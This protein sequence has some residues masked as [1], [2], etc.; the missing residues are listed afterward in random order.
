MNSYIQILKLKNIIYLFLVQLLI[1]NTEHITINKSTFWLKKI[2]ANIDYSGGIIKIVPSES[3]N[4]LS[5]FIEYNPELFQPNLEFTSLSRIGILDLSTNFNFGLNLNSDK[6]NYGNT[7]EIFLPTATPIKFNLNYSLATVEMDLN[8]VE[9][10]T[11]NFDLGLGSAITNFGNEYQSDCGFFNVDIG[12]GSAEFKNIGNLNCEEYEIA[13]GMGSII[14][15]FS[16]ENN[17]DIEYEISLGMGYIEIYVPVNKNVIFKTNQSIL[18]NLDLKE[19]N[20]IKTNIYRNKNFK[21]EN[22]TL[23]FHSTIG[24]GSITL[25]WIK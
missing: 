5:G 13:C 17:L 18:A 21:E 12:L 8:E 11:F 14:L 24:L 6:K 3:S 1:G 22:P 10:S 16:G 7:A 25:N 19:M 4:E 9:I 20:L 2:K 23:T 15:D